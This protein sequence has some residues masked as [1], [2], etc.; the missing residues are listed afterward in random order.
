MSLD[1][2]QKQFI[3]Y[4]LSLAEKGHEDRGGLADLRS[5]LGREP[6]LMT[7]VH[8]HVAPFLPAERHSDRWY[9]LVATLFGAYPQHR[10]NVSL[11]KALAP[12]RWMSASIEARFTALL[13]ANAEEL[14]DHLRHVI[15]LLRAHERPLD[16]FRLFSDLLHWD[17][18]SGSVQLAWAR[19]FYGYQAAP[20]PFTAD[21]GEA[22]EASGDEG[23]S[24]E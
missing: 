14:D 2:G 9:Y 15:G 17:D 6:G 3:G 19:D 8:R 13:N 24:D 4:L 5:G 23:K 20:A 16:W 11:G 10:P 1:E 18:L 21:M 7:R 22:S 12:L